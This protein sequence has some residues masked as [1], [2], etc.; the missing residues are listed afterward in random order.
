MSSLRKG[1]TWGASK[2]SSSAMRAHG[3]TV[4]LTTRQ[5]RQRRARARANKSLLPVG[6]L[7]PLCPLCCSTG[8]G[9]NIKAY[10]SDSEQNRVLFILIYRDVRPGYWYRKYGGSCCYP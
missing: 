1:V 9:Q 5:R 7:G 10:S 3:L 4:S 6:A 8:G 2:T